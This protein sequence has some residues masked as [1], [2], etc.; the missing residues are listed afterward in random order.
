LR[1]DF[2]YDE[3]LELPKKPSIPV[4]TG[5]DDDD[6]YDDVTI[7][8]LDPMKLIDEIRLGKQG[9][10]IDRDL[11]PSSQ[12]RYSKRSNLERNG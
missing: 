9:M 3:I 10:R 5:D 6:D 12:E 4:D 2:D 1:K 11:Y 7:D 8:V